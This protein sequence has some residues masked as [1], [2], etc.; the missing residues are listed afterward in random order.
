MLVRR[1][2][3]ILMVLLAQVARA[4][5]FSDKLSIGM[6]PDRVASALGV[7]PFDTDCKEV[8]SIKS[9]TYKYKRA[10]FDTEQFTATFYDVTFVA[11]RMVSVST[12]TRRGR[13]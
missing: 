6:V 2:C 11:D 1:G 7:L 4:D 3:A 8:L 9:C 12:K 13:F 10:E 5:A